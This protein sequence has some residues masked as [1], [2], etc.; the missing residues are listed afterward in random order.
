M[1][2]ADIPAMHQGF[3]VV[4]PYLVILIALALYLY[5]RAQLR[6]GVLR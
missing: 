1:R 6:K 2:P 3:N 5:S 4:V